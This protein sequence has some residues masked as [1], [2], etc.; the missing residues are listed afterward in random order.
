MRAGKQARKKKVFV[1]AQFKMQ[2]CLQ[3]V[4]LVC[5]DAVT[6]LGQHFRS[7]FSVASRALLSSAAVLSLPK[8]SR[9]LFSDEVEVSLQGWDGR[10][11]GLSLVD[12]VKT[13]SGVNS[14]RIV[15]GRVADEALPAIKSS[16]QQGMVLVGVNN[17]NIE[18]YRRE[19]VA[20]RIKASP[21][22]K[23]LQ[24]TFRDPDIL[25]RR[26]NSTTSS[27]DVTTSMLLPPA[28][29]GGRGVPSAQILRVER[30]ERGVQNLAAVAALGDVL[31]LSFC[32]SRA[33][34]GALLGA[35][36]SSGQVL[37]SGAG[38]SDDSV[39]IVLGA[40]AGLSAV[41][42]PAALAALPSEALL[43][44]RGMAPGELRK[45]TLPPLL[46]GAYGGDVE[47]LV[48]LLSLNGRT[49]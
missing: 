16:I 2:F 8:A 13:R 29:S 10:S 20:V 49:K 40:A 42:L 45:V 19:D 22:D 31:E 41:K 47:L 26:L 12:V 37:A 25:F 36:P 35:S 43:L 5:A 18:G 27:A 3:L 15:V 4:L 1:A 46:S 33:S 34:D 39:F 23:P 32:I 9:A 44:L 24:L 30:V 14:V 7:R 6:N 21:V 48:R 11:L 28:K 17:E 38:L